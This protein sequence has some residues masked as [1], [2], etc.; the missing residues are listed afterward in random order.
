MDSINDQQVN[1]VVIELFKKQRELTPPY[2]PNFPS[3]LVN[4]K[5]QGSLNQNFFSK[6]TPYGKKKTMPISFSQD[7]RF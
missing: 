3:V 5:S 2:K 4:N 1:L 6:R 7:K